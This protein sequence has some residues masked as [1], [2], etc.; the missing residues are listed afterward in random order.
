MEQAPLWL[1]HMVTKGIGS[2]QKNLSC[3]SLKPVLKPGLQAKNKPN[4]ICMTGQ[5]P[6]KDIGELLSRLFIVIIAVRYRYPKKTY[7]LSCRIRWIML[8]KGKHLWLLQ[9]IG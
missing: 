8:L 5:S 7:R 3:Q 2:L 9:K 6:G 1:C 4:I